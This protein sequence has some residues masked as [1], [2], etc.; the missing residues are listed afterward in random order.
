[1]HRHTWKGFVRAG[2][3]WLQN[4]RANVAED[5][6]QRGGWWIAAVLTMAVMMGAFVWLFGNQVNE[7]LQGANNVTTSMTTQTGLNTIADAAIN[8]N[9]GL[10]TLGT[11]TTAGTGFSSTAPSAFKAP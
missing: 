8:N 4:E 9:V 10:N 11:G 6:T 5:N 1:M 7:A 2:W 3:R